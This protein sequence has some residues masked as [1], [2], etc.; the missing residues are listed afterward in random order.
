MRY[1]LMKSEPS[2]YSIDDLRRDRRELWTG[3]RN[4]QA[5]NFMRDQM[6]RG[7]GA[8]FYHSGKASAAG[9]APGIAGIA[10]VSSAQAVAD[11]TQFDSAS[12]YYDSASTAEN[13]RWVCA[14]VQFVRKTKFLPLSQIRAEKKLAA[15]HLL[16]KGSRL[17]IT[18]VS[19]DEWQFIVEKM[20]A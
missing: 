11:P 4:Y 2:D 13:T 7:D 9:L 5:R 19:A 15:M 17:S 18:P 12:R 8:L 1:W 3:V 6:H 20:L 16:R 14:E 10:E